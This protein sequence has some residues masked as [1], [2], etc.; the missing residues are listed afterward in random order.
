MG[1]YFLTAKESTKLDMGHNKIMLVEQLFSVKKVML[2]IYI[3][4][5]TGL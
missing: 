2:A 5:W 1:S 3:W 4:R